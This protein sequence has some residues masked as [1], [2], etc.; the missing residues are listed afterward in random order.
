V[1]RR[2]SVCLHAI[3]GDCC[4]VSDRDGALAF[5]GFVIS[6]IL[7]VAAIVT[8]NEKLRLKLYRKLA[9]RS[10]NPEKI[11]ERD[12]E[13]SGSDELINIPAKN[14]ELS[15]WGMLGLFLFMFVSLG[16]VGTLIGL[17]G[18]LTSSLFAF[19][20][21]GFVSVSA[22]VSERPLVPVMTSVFCITVA[23]VT[24][25]VP[26]W[27]PTQIAPIP[28]SAT[29]T[30]ALDKPCHTWMYFL[31]FSATLALAAAADAQRNRL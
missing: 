14:D 29:M 24:V 2:G 20:L 31:M 18:G 9:K 16:I 11:D 27:P 10:K 25:L 7:I 15:G 28:A 22:T 5:C 23:F 1:A 26:P 30:L 17:T 21:A 3:A 6:L 12:A 8:H 4:R 19:L 13:L